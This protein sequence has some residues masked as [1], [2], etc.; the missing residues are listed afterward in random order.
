MSALTINR[1]RMN[2]VM[3][4]PQAVRSWNQPEYADRGE[5]MH[6]SGLS[7]K[8]AAQKGLYYKDTNGKKIRNVSEYA[9]ADPVDVLFP[10]WGSMG[11]FFADDICY[12]Y[13][14]VETNRPSA[15]NGGYEYHIKK[16]TPDHGTWTNLFW[17]T[18][19]VPFR[20]YRAATKSNRII[21]IHE[22]NGACTVTLIDPADGNRETITATMLTDTDDVENRPTCQTGNVAAHYGTVYTT[23]TSALKLAGH[24]AE[25]IAEAL[26]I[27][28]SVSQAYDPAGVRTRWTDG[29]TWTVANGATYWATC[30]QY[31]TNY[32]EIQYKEN[33]ET[34]YDGIP[35]YYSLT[36]EG[37]LLNRVD[38]K[39]IFSQGRRPL[40][41]VFD[42][43]LNIPEVDAG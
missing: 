38:G 35:V 13:L 41:A 32:Y 10:E 9:D 28:G 25:P 30:H 34:V 15:A 23:K 1:R 14:G 17:A 12:A 4:R 31:A 3:L 27:G 6:I 18:T 37:G 16:H 40:K 20:P 42:D 8:Q 33:G 11:L 22:I 2:N 7:L 29:K 39:I 43:G 24:I 5:P 21:D 26:K 19:Y 36:R